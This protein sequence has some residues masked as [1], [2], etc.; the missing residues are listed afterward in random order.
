MGGAPNT[1]NAPKRRIID[2]RGKGEGDNYE[3][4][5]QAG[6]FLVF[7]GR[8]ANEHVRHTH[9]GVSY[10]FCRMWEVGVGGG[11]SW[12]RKT[13]LFG[14]VFRVLAKRGGDGDAPG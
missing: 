12:T 5:A 11:W 9:M 8:K 4:R 2:V 7:L 13:R 6:V 14:R 3:K 10:V 1:K